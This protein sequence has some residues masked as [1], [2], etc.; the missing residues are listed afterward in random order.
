[1][2]IAKIIATSFYSRPVRF[3]TELCGDPPVYT[4]HSQNFKTNKEIEDLILFNIEQENKCNPGIPVDLVFVNN[5]VGNKKGNQ[6][7]NSLSNKKLNY[8]NIIV[9]QNDN[10]GWS[11][12]AYNRGFQ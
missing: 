5:N 8:G 12:G 11:Y 4:L 9:I 1:M 6:F 7:V 3:N 2:K 10:K